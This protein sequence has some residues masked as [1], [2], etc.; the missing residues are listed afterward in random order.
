MMIDTLFYKN[1]F[2]K[3]LFYKNIEAQIDPD[4]KNLL[5]TA[6]TRDKAFFFICVELKTHSNSMNLYRVTFSLS[7]YNG[8]V[9]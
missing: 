9:F 7:K 2:H 8:Y 1:L 4:V 5:R 3:N 6:E